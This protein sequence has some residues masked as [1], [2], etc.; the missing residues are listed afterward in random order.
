[1]Y[2]STNIIRVK[3]AVHVTRIGEARS[4]LKI[5][6]GKPERKRPSGRPRHRWEDN[7]R[8]DLME[9][10]REDV[11]WMHL[12]QSRDEGWATVN[13]VMKRRVP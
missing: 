4:E 8:I 6:V 9:I 7:I 13:T 1:L 5:L 11:D 3:W 2:A 10:G 12:V